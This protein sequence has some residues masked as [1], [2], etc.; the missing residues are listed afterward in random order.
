MV[1]CSYSAAERATQAKF[2]AS[3]MIYNKQHHVSRPPPSCKWHELR[4]A[5]VRNV[6]HDPHR[7]ASCM[8]QPQENRTQNSRSRHHSPCLAAWKSSCHSSCA[9]KY[10]FESDVLIFAWN[11]ACR[12]KSYYGTYPCRRYNESSV[13]SCSFSFLD[14]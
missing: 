13:G 5:N 3:N 2:H 6:R 12:F 4:E 14:W 1:T 7:L 11:E 9:S 8:Q 10:V